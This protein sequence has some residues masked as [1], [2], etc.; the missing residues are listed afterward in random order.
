MVILDY[1]MQGEGCSLFCS[2]LYSEHIEETEPEA[3]LWGKIMCNKYIYLKMIPGGL[4]A[5]YVGQIKVMKFQT[6]HFLICR[7]HVM[8]EEDR[9]ER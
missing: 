1:K 4:F 9:I 7:P 5:K 2:L 8:H 6:K 3:C